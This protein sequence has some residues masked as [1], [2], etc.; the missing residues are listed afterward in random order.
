[1]RSTALAKRHGVAPFNNLR[2]NQRNLSIFL[3]ILVCFGTD[4]LFAQLSEDGGA[5]Y[6][7][8]SCGLS[9]PKQLK[10][11]KLVDVHQFE[12][13]GSDVMVTF[14]DPDKGLR[15]SLCVYKSPTETKGPALM[16][17]SGGKEILENRE[18]EKKSHHAVFKLTTPAEA[19][20][21]EYDQVI[22]AIIATD[23]MIDTKL[24]SEFRFMAVPTRKDSPIAYV[25]ELSGTR[26]V[27]SEN[28]IPWTWKTYLYAI[29]GFFVKIHCTYPSQLWLEI[30]PI[31]VDLIQAINWDE[32]IPPAGQKASK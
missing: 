3:S 25:A 1:M 14:T 20:L 9:I 19:Y 4:P 10:N 12:S 30:G 26:K 16:L 29:P 8:S 28:V 2:M 31:D 5:R 13:D 11:L 7:F 17:D 24:D 22:K 6:V 32:I 27:R 23:F 21:R 18:D 15:V